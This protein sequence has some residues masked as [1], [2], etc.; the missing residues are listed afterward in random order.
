MN[1]ED[2]VG[3]LRDV[4]QEDTDLL[5]YH[6]GRWRVE[7]RLLNWQQF[8]ARIF[9]A[10]LD[11]FQACAVEVLGEV[12]PQFELEPE[13]RYAAGIHGKVLK[14]S[15][16]LREGISETLALL[17]NQGDALKNCSANKPETTAMLIIRELFEANDWR[18]WASVNHLLPNM[19]EGAPREFLDSVQR[20]LSSDTCPFDEVFKQEGH[21]TF[22]GTYISG[23]LWA[24]E[25][26]AWSDDYL[27]R[28][29][30]LLADLAAR[31]PGGAWSNR[32]DNSIVAI[33]LPWHP[34]TL[35]TTEKRLACMRAIKN[36]HPDIAWSV[37]MRL[38]PNQQQSTSGTHKP[39][40]FIALEE[41]WKPAVSH[42][43]YYE[44][45][46]SYA[47][48]AIEMAFGDL[49]NLT[50]LVGYLDNLPQVAFDK[51]I[52]HLTSDTVV[53]LNEEERLPI[54]SKLKRFSR[55]HR[56]FQDAKWALPLDVI[57][58]LDG[59]AERLKPVS[60]EGMYQHLFTHND[61]DLYEENGDWEKQRRL[62]DEKRTQA[63]LAI[64]NDGGLERI[65]AFVENVSAPHQIGWALAEAVDVSLEKAILPD[66]FGSSKQALHFVDGFVL[67]TYLNLGSEWL[68]KIPAKTWETE[69]K[70]QLLIRLPF[71]EEA[72]NRA[73]E[74]QGE[75]EKHY[76]S[77]VRVNPYGSEGN[78]LYA[79][80]KLIK[81]GRP[82]AAIE[83]L[84]V[85]LH[86]ERHLD[87]ARAIDALL[88]AV[89]TDEPPNTLD[90]H[91][92]LE[93]IKA[94]QEDP[95][96]DPDGLFRVEWAYVSL[97]DSHGGVKPRLLEQKLATEPEFFCEAIQLIYRPKG[98]EQTEVIDEDKKT[99]A[100][101]AWRLLHEWKHPPGLQEDGT[102][103]ADICIQWLEAV[104]K[105]CG[106]SGRLDVA[107]VK[108][109][110]VLRYS[111]EDPDGL[112]INDE[113]ARQLNSTDAET[114]RDGFRTEVFN[115]RGVHWVDPTGDPER[116]LAE[117]WRQKAV[118]VEEVGY[119][120]FGATLRQLADSYDRDADRVVAD[121]FNDE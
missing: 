76:W 101:N 54:W 43:D 61:S 85:R 15:G 18:T 93:L 5:N 75:D 97:L 37:L 23:L 46:A 86:N 31:D 73:A 90:Q 6:E 39:K 42:A 112:W 94:L 115:S 95:A 9:D 121:H 34:Q 63:V 14:H 99:I 49:A 82:I 30:T 69:Q 45:I 19:A 35:A 102:F 55:K 110:E 36:D 103:A 24:L 57:D 11:V 107:L 106:E 83:C 51:V 47:E 17:G 33:L 81:Y 109:G 98:A 68:D 29:A 56:R 38:L 7:N 25:G 70:T 48:L 77:E 41:D 114:M 67:K 62:L 28:V 50:E 91:Y 80:D 65:L 88:R 58:K 92:V 40:W 20:A 66:L 52:D 89:S 116:E 59:V 74:W 113:V 26:L 21:G 72:W 118:A 53:D 79:V 16:T 96:T 100:T 78:L 12:D 2:W 105:L 60:P 120:R 84:Y 64:W 71:D 111:P 108:V 87:H 1:F 13:E 3:S 117:Q 22:G 10:H 44:Q 8:G 119:A 27:V 32:P 4:I 104:K